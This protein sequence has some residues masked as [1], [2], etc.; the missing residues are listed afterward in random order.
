MKFILLVTMIQLLSAISAQADDPVLEAKQQR[1]GV[2]IR[3]GEIL[4]QASQIVLRQDKQHSFFFNRFLR[5]IAELQI[6]AHDFDGALSSIRKSEY[7]Y[8]QNEA[9]VKLAEALATDGQ[10]EKAFEV[11]AELG[12]DHGWKQDRIDDGVLACWI[13]YLISTD[14]L[15]VAQKTLG[16]FETATARSKG[17]TKL[18]L[19]YASNRDKTTAKRLFKNAIAA[20]AEVSYEFFQ[21]KALWEIVDA[22]LEAG[23]SDA[24]VSTVDE[25]VNRSKTFE[26]GWTRV[27]AFCEAGIRKAR[28]KDKEAAKMLFSQAIEARKMV[29]ESN[30]IPSLKVIAMAQV[31]AGLIDDARNTAAMIKHSESDFTQDGRREEVLYA[32]A[33]AL[34]KDGKLAEATET[35]K[36]IKHYLQYQHDAF[37]A[38]VEQHIENGDNESALATA[39]EVANP[40]R[41]AAAM[42]KIA[43]KYAS[44][45]DKNKAK[46][47]ASAVRL[48]VAPDIF[49]L[50]DEDLVFEWTKPAT[51]GVLYDDRGYFTAL[52]HSFTVKR[53]AELAAAAM[54]LAQVLNEDGKVDYADS[55]EEFE[56]SVIESLAQA[57][58]MYGDETEA[59]KWANKIGSEKNV[60]HENE[61]SKVNAALRR[62]HALV[63]V[64]EGM[65]EK[66]SGPAK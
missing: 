57:H 2:E 41:K 56:D 7:S 13:D 55:F 59:L 46:E 22:Q 54:T 62:I 23:E 29:N 49:L 17:S 53:A 61:Y 63:G 50:S 26:D 10:K 24:A 12:S 19:V 20:A 15:E 30:K 3:A 65:L 33:I 8:G 21:A 42:L 44:S 14:Q 4:G 66:H 36:S 25:L 43:S 39:L 64:A 58:A 18:A 38:I 60:K 31:S 32:I 1:T 16:E 48:R 40:T 5:K 51:W 47:I 45:G 37:L 34:L 52:S 6:R 11:I 28:M 9:F 27:R 35:A